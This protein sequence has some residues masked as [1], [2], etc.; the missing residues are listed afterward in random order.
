L[1]RRR[2]DSSGE[3]GR[4]GRRVYYFHEHQFD[5]RLLLLTRLPSSLSCRPMQQQARSKS[6]QHACTFMSLTVFL[7]FGIPYGPM[8]ARASDVGTVTLPSCADLVPTGVIE[9]GTSAN[10]PSSCS[11][12]T[13]P[14]FVYQ[15]P[16]C[17]ALR[18]TILTSF[19]YRNCLKQSR[20]KSWSVKVGSSVLHLGWGKRAPV[21]PAS[22]VVHSS[23]SSQFTTGGE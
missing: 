3:K 21:G 5:T 11:E 7:T 16:A 19:E 18:T 23:S 8:M 10:Q 20:D 14:L 1:L 15:E 9:L 22:G 4:A 17:V 12:R 13:G 2:T 6:N